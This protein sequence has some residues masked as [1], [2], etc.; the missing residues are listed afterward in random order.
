MSLL[1][2]SNRPAR[3]WLGAFSLLSPGGFDGWGKLDVPL[4]MAQYAA[5]MASADEMSAVCPAQYS[6]TD[7]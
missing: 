4:F 6:L 3:R 1:P 5:N 7:V 2:I